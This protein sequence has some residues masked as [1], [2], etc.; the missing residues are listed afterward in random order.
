MSHKATQRTG[1][2]NAEEELLTYADEVDIL[3]HAFKLTLPHKIEA[4][5]ELELKADCLP[6][7]KTSLTRTRRSQ[8]VM[9]KEYSSTST[10]VSAS[11]ATK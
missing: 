10:S 4:W 3:S 5:N 9:T 2:S 11:H 8:S 7:P 6:Q 1:C